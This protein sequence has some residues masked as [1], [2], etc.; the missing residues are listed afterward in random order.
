MPLKP[1]TIFKGADFTQADPFAPEKWGEVLMD[2]DKALI[3]EAID[4]ARRAKAGTP[5]E[6]VSPPVIPPIVAGTPPTIQHQ[7]VPRPGASKA[8]AASFPCV[9]LKFPN[10]PRDYVLKGEPADFL[11][12]GTP[13]VGEDKPAAKPGDQAPKPPAK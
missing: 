8:H 2:T 9:S 6:A 5:P 3:V 10:D 7:P 13:P 1:V 12:G 4:P 11:P